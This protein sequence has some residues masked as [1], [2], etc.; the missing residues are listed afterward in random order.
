MRLR[1]GSCDL[2]VLS[3][4]EAQLEVAH[5]QGGRRRQG[6]GEHVQLGQPVQEAVLYIKDALDGRR[7][8]HP[9]AGQGARRAHL[10][11]LNL[12]WP[13]VRV[14]LILQIVLCFFEPPAWCVLDSAE[15]R[16]SP[17]ENERNIYP[18][19]GLPYSERRRSYRPPPQIA[20]SSPRR[21]KPSQKIFQ[22]SSLAVVRRC[23]AVRPL[24]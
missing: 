6:S 11:Q 15:E 18:V 24:R 13:I 5:D 3:R 17:C 1:V 4:E 10:R 7:H 20:Q 8:V 12:L 14:V 21:S 2:G 16:A 23:C 19:F 9:Q 22:R